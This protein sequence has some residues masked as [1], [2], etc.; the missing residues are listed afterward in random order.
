MNIKEFPDYKTVKNAI[1]RLKNQ[2]IEPFNNDIHNADSYSNMIIQDIVENW[3]QFNIF[4]T[5]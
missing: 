1:S 3:S 5:I 2:S 4:K